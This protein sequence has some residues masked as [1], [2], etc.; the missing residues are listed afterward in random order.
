ML[1]V[2]L[3]VVTKVSAQSQESPAV[4]RVRYVAADT[5]YVEGGTSA[6]LAEGMTL[7]V[8]RPGPGESPVAAAALAE[9]KVVSVA[10]TSAACE[11]VR[12]DMPIQPGDLAIA[13]AGQLAAARAANG[14]P[15]ETFAQVVEFTGEEDP[16]DREIRESLPKPPLREENHLGGRI[17]FEHDSILD[18]SGSGVRSHQ[19]GITFRA[20]MTRIGGTY[21]SFTGYWRGR[22]QSRNSEPA[23]QS[24]R[25]VLQRVYQFSLR[26]DSPDSRYVA[27]LGRLLVPWA[28]SLSTIDGGYFGRKWGR[29]ST[30]GLFA[31]TTPD[32][33]AW[34]YDPNRQVA[35]AFLGLDHG[36]FDSARHTATIGVALSRLDWR[37]ERQ[38]VF[39]E[40]GLA[41]GRTLSVRYNLEADYQSR[42]RFV[43]S[44][45]VTLTRS[46][47]TSRLQPVSRVSFDFS[48]S[49]FRVL[50]TFDSRLIAAGLV[51]NA[52]FHGLSAGVR[53]EVAPGLAVYGT[54]GRSRRTEDRTPSWSHM[55][56]VV[57]RLPVV[58]LRADVRYSRFDGTIGAGE[59]RSA[60]LS[61]E[62]SNR[63]RFEVQVGDQTLRSNLITASRSRFGTAT[64]DWFV[65]RFVIGSTGLRYRGGI[66]YYDQ[67]AIHLDYR[68]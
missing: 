65:G 41:I 20:D 40:D 43:A 18:R 46:F 55:A 63:W 61:K 5:V 15:E 30:V 22:I 29:G 45:P 8:K 4:F 52:L 6:G 14:S 31:G 54:A 64:M 62:S 44:T 10:S 50:P 11:V 58:G 66:Q 13:D 12:S 9:L 23:Q 19:T 47:F 56:G 2:C 3:S 59:Y 33:T 42:D 26:Y 53:I 49:Y 1:T 48:H 16:I 39:L 38:F 51:D 36:S 32:P 57:T 7:L 28:S 25:D 60:L 17:G 67:L 27:G 37:P 35:G 34:N 68:F 24:L 21:W